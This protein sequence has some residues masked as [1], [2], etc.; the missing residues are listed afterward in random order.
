MNKKGAFG[1]GLVSSVLFTA[2]TGNLPSWEAIKPNNGNTISVGPVDTTIT[3][4]AAFAVGEISGTT[5][6]DGSYHYHHPL[7]PDCDVSIE[8]KFP[9]IADPVIQL[10]D[11]AIKVGT[12]NSSGKVPVDVTIN[13]QVQALNPRSDP[14]IPD[15]RETDGNGLLNICDPPDVGHLVDKVMQVS[16]AATD[17]SANCMVR[18]LSATTTTDQNGDVIQTDASK[19]IRKIYDDD[20]KLDIASLFATDSGLVT[21]HWTGDSTPFDPLASPVLTVLH[22]SITS[23]SKDGYTVNADAVNKC[24]FSALQIDISPVGSA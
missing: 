24:T 17:T 18:T 1:L 2:A 9:F 3:H 12:P 15:I 7:I 22:D 14:V 20:I 8:A 23:N 19:A 11:L 21:T 13:G 5:T 6:V 4:L 10:A 16:G